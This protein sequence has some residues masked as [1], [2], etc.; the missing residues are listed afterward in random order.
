MFV[1]LTNHVNKTEIM[2]KEETKNEKT[3]YR[4]EFFTTKLYFEFLIFSMSL[5]LLTP[6][7]GQK[8]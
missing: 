4:E 6:K 8:P 5:S 7:L 3:V 1:L 2:Y